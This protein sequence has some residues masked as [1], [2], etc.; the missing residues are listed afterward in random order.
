MKGSLNCSIRLGRI[1]KSLGLSF[2]VDG[3]VVLVVE[4]RLI[5]GP[6]C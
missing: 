1:G 2:C 5:N 6:T 3:S 4:C